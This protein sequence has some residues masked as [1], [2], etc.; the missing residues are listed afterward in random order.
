MENRKRKGQR[1][2]SAGTVVMLVSLRTTRA[3]ALKVMSSSHKESYAAPVSLRNCMVHAP[4][5]IVCLKAV[6]KNGNIAQ[7]GCICP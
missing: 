3:P 7:A 2:I 5:I 1:C 4:V 6:A